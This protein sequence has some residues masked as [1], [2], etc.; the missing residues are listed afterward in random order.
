M[1]REE[2]IRQADGRDVVMRSCWNCNGA[3]AHLK[4]ADYVVFCVAGCGHFYWKGVQLD[5]N[6]GDANCQKEDLPS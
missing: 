1:T 2:A 4:G 6:E 5:N 3:H